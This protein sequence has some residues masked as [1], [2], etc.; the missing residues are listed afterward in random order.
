MA[1]S[2]VPK[3]IDISAPPHATER[4]KPWPESQCAHQF[5]FFLVLE[6]GLIAELVRSNQ[7]S[8][9]TYCRGHC[10]FSSFCDT[11]AVYQNK[12]TETQL[13]SC[14]PLCKLVF[15]KLR[16][17][18][19]FQDVLSPPWV[20]VTINS[21]ASIYRWRKQHTGIFFY[22]WFNITLSVT[23][24][25][26]IIIKAKW[27]CLDEVLHSLTTY[28][29]FIWCWFMHRPTGKD[30]HKQFFPS[31][32]ALDQMFSQ[33]KDPG[34]YLSPA[35]DLWHQT[36]IWKDGMELDRWH[37][38]VS[39]LSLTLNRGSFWDGLQQWPLAGVELFAPRCRKFPLPWVAVASL[40]VTLGRGDFSRGDWLYSFLNVR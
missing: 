38:A 5:V 35:L 33:C 19:K 20:V 37:W 4:P 29:H 13:S 21:L 30:R 31:K 1:P 12:W 32:V 26:W 8:A 28:F 9:Q 6:V 25:S 7:S 39:L 14:N 24:L 22:F 3:P 11:V 36:W 15:G 40:P 27:V 2:S 18:M 16:L 10:R 34:E 17:R 23:D